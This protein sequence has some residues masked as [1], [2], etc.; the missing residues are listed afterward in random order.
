[1]RS[2]D[3]LTEKQSDSNMEIARLYRAAKERF[4]MYTKEV[5]LVKYLQSGSS[6]NEKQ[7]IKMNASIKQL[8]KDVKKLDRQVNDLEKKEIKDLDKRVNSLEKKIK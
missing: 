8:E 3:F 7:D 5:A 1:M 4:P 6:K 2:K